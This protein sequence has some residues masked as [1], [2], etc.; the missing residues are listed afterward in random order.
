MAITR[1]PTVATPKPPAVD[2]K[3]I[4]ALISKGGS[5]TLA[6]ETAAS[7]DEDAIKPVLVRTYESQLQEID[8]LLAQIPKRNRPSRNAFIVEAIEEKMQR[9]KNK[10][11]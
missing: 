5:S 8:R 1:T 7:E 11:K 2:E 4:E 10:R 3:K 6:K 9:E